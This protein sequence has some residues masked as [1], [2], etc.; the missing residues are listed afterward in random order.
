[1]EQVKFQVSGPELGRYLQGGG[2]GLGGFPQLLVDIA[3]EAQQ[4][5]S[6]S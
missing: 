5:L 2:L 1:M 3:A 6:N 4:D